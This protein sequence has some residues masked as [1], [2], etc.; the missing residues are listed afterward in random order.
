MDRAVTE[1]RY[2][3]GIKRALGFSRRMVMGEIILEAGLL[4]SAGLIL[5]T[6]VAL[7]AS[8]VTFA[9]WGPADA[10]FSAAWS[11]RGIYVLGLYALG[12]VAVMPAAWKAAN[13][14]PAEMMRTGE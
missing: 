5:G 6:I 1:R 14:P 10:A 12:L 2:E 8:A 7:W 3:Y 4:A 11:D 9:M 13:M